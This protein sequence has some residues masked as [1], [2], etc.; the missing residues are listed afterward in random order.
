MLSLKGMRPFGVN[1]I[2]K[3][4]GLDIKQ[5]ISYH[6]GQSLYHLGGIF[7]KPNG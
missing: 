2:L 4:C 6:L 3:P 5:I 7:E 1:S